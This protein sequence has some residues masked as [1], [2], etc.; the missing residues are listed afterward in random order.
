MQSWFYPWTYLDTPSLDFIFYTIPG[1]EK[2][3]EKPK[4]LTLNSKGK[5]EKAGTSAI[6]G[7]HSKNLEYVCDLSGKLFIKGI[8][9]GLSLYFQHLEADT[10]R[11]LWVPSQSNVYSEF[12]DSQGYKE[13]PCL[14]KPKSKPKQY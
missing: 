13:R 12:Q 10:G 3:G 2:K 8:K 6:L 7:I 1:A 5:Q 14:K 4:A 11:P 9:L